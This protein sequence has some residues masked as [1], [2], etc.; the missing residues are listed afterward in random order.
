VIINGAKYYRFLVQHFTAIA[1]C[2]G[3]A[4]ML[5]INHMLFWLETSLAHGLACQQN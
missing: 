4:E 3:L 1:F 5:K 2:C